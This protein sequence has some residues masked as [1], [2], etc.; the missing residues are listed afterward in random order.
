LGVDQGATPEEMKR[1]RDLVEEYSRNGMLRDD[2]MLMKMNLFPFQLGADRNKGWE[3]ISE[4]M[5]AAF[6]FQNL[7]EY[8]RFVIEHRKNSIQKMVVEKKPKL[9]W[10][11]GISKV[12]HFGNAFA[13]STDFDS[14]LDGNIRKKVLNKGKTILIVTPFFSPAWL[15]SNEN[16]KRVAEYFADTLKLSDTLR[17][18][19]EKAKVAC[20]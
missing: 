19:Y 2:G 3:N 18:L 8:E 15:K 5:N 4:Q 1:L 7:D 12:R 17:E 11:I 20:E 9:I 6:G 14:E 16:K 13:D 10:C